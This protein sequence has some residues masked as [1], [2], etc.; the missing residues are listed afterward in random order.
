MKLKCISNLL[1]VIVKKCKVIL[2]M[3]LMPFH[4]LCKENKHSIMKR[5][6]P[7]DKECMHYT[8]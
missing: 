1:V 2:D 4:H 5:L 7:K 3:F 6:A 8:V